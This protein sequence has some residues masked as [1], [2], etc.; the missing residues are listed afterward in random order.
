MGVEFAEHHLVSTVLQVG[1]K[2]RGTGRRTA[3][4]GNIDI[5]KG[6]CYPPEVGL[7]CQDFRRGIV[8]EY[9]IIKHLAGDGMVDESVKSTTA[10]ERAFAPDGAI[11]C[12]L[13]E[14]R[15]QH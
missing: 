6:Y 3:G 10:S 7:N 9:V 4:T 15:V 11:L 2:I 14:G 5:K 12:E 13:F 1:V 8:W